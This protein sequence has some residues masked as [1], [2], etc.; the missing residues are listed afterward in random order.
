M[1]HYFSGLMNFYTSSS[2]DTSAHV[3][4]YVYRNATHMLKYMNRDTL[5]EISYTYHG[6]RYCDVW[7]N[8]PTPTYG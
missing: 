2:G 5:S 1:N 8:R 3:S 6:P 7:M 4:R